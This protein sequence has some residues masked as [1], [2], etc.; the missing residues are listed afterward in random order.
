[1]SDVPD[2]FARADRSANL[3]VSGQVGAG[4]TML[5]QEIAQSEVA[6]YGAEVYWVDMRGA[7]VARLRRT[8]QDLRRR[9]DPSRLA[10]LVVDE[11]HGISRADLHGELGTL[12]GNIMEGAREHRERT[13]LTSYDPGVFRDA[14]GSLVDAQCQ[15][16]LAGPATADGLAWLDPRLVPYT[17]DPSDRRTI[18]RGLHLPRQAKAEEDPMDLVRP[19]WVSRR[20]RLTLR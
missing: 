12:L 13:I 1:M 3:L 7:T 9:D 4:K 19:F 2:V 14:F 11:M 16:I 17:E 8:L 18:G 10:V 15:K 20:D 6:M 5:V